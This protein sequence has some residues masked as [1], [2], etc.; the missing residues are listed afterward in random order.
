MRLIEEIKQV[1]N[2]GKAQGRSEADVM[3]DVRVIMRKHNEEILR[4]IWLQNLLDDA[5]G[6]K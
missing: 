2:E 6:L 5:V 1:V 4:Q 3:S